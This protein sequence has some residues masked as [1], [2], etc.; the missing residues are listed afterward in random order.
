MN[1]WVYIDAWPIYLG[2]TLSRHANIDKEIARR[3][4][5]ASVSFGS[6]RDKVWEKSGISVA[7]KLQVY[8]A[9]VL[10]SLLYGCETWTVYARHAKKQLFPHALLTKHPTH[11][12]GGQNPLHWCTGEGKSS[13]PDYRMPVNVILFWEREGGGGRLHALWAGWNWS[14]TPVWRSPTHAHLICPHPSNPPQGS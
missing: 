12:V 9:V 13:W 1:L 3:L 2:S 8:K 7:T 14:P 5:K 10:P 6:L 4:A 11:Q